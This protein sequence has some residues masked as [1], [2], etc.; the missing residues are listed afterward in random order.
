MGK[1]KVS[2]NMNELRVGMVLAQEIR[3]DNNTVLVGE[4]I[5][6]NDSIINSLKK[7]LF[8]G[9]V[10]IY[11]QEKYEKNNSIEIK[12]KTAEDIDKDF[13]EFTFNAEAIFDNMYSAGTPGLNEV[14]NFAKKI[15]GE[16]ESANAIVKNIVLYGS[17]TD[18]VYRHSVNVAALSSLLA[19][20]IGFDE[21]DISLLT[22]SAILHDIGKIK[23]SPEVLNKTNSLTVSEFEKIKKHPIIGYDLV[24]EIAYLGKSVSYG[25]LMHHERVDGS[26]YPLGIKGEKIHQFAK[27]IAIV[28]VF[29]AINSN[30]IYKKRKAPFEALELI[31][32]ESLGKLDYEYSKIFLQR[33]VN[34]YIG[35]E[36]LLNTQK[37]CKIVQVDINDISRPLLF[38]GSEFIDLKREKDLSIES[39]V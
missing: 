39:L 20:W 28:D 35:E 10:S 29:D 17:G 25:V 15:Q 27:V 21:K 30:R 7:K 12:K 34:Y 36:V 33:I 6:V 32:K 22:Y 38:D 23:I 31:Q 19:A 16:L 2:I 11:T 5:V 4:G 3:T 8:F 18:S 24:K 26:G 14:R 1:V 9:K 37:I 13:S